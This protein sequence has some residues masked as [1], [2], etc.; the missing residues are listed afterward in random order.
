VSGPLALEAQLCFTLSLATRTVG[1]IYRPLLAELDLTHAQ[2]LVMLALWQHGPMPVRRLG[3]LLH[4]DSGTLSPLVQ[5]L[6]ARG[7]VRRDRHHDD[8]RSV[9]V[10]LTTDG[11]ALRSRAE[12]VPSAVRDRLGLPAEDLLHLQAVLAEV[13]AA[14]RPA[15]TPGGT[16]TSRSSGTPVTG[17]M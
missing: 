5:R 15:A 6:E 14:A 10:T 3:G 13:I 7:L 11:D 4:L 8:Q 17:S 12:A 16:T 1:A 2:Y 9:T